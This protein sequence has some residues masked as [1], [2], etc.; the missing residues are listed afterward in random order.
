MLGGSRPQAGAREESRR[1]LAGEPQMQRVPRLQL[2]RVACGRRK[3]KK[4][5]ERKASRGLGGRALTHSLTPVTSLA[6]KV[7]PSLRW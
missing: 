2:Q 3:E 5:E 1:R 4:K 6:A 7:T